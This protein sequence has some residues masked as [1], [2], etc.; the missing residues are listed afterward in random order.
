M[1]TD[2]LK[3]ESERFKRLT[4]SLKTDKEVST[5]YERLIICPHCGF[6]DCDDRYDGEG[7]HEYTCGSC[8]KDY[9]CSVHV[10]FSYSTYRKEVSA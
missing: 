3:K 8:G 1:L 7:C 6:D 5:Q 9:T 10:S 4:E 2:Y